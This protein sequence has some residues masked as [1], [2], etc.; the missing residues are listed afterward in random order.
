MLVELDVAIEIAIFISCR[1]SLIQVAMLF[2]GKT[3]ECATLGILYE[4][5]EGQILTSPFLGL[6]NSRSQV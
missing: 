5:S 6:G 1:R 4:V 2:V 3:K